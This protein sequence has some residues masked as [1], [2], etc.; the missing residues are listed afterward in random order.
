MRNL[1]NKIY[2]ISVL[3]TVSLFM[4]TCSDDEKTTTKLSEAEIE[5][6]VINYQ[7]ASHVIDSLVIWECD[8]S[9]DLM[10][11]YLDEIENLP[12][13]ENV[14][15]EN[16][17]FC[18]NLENVG[19][20][21][22]T[23]IPEE[24]ILPFSPLAGEETG[25]A[26]EAMTLSREASLLRAYDSQYL[27]TNKNVCLINQQSNDLSRQFVKQSLQKMKR[28]FEKKEF[29]VE[30]KDAEDFTRDFLKTSIHNY[31]IVFIKTH[32][33]YIG[34]RH[35]ML[36]GEEVS[37]KN[38]EEIRDYIEENSF[39]VEE[40]R[41]R[42][43]LRFLTAERNISYIAVNEVFINNQVHD[44][45]DN[46]IIFST[47]CQSLQDGNELGTAFINKNAGA[48][49]GYT[50]T[51]GIGLDAAYNLFSFM[52][53]G[54]TIEKAYDVLA[55]EYKKQ[56]GARNDVSYLAELK[57]VPSSGKNIY[58]I[59][60]DSV[61][62][63][64]TSPEDGKS[65]EQ[66]TILLS[67][68]TENGE[69]IR[70]GTVEINGRSYILDINPIDS[71]RFSQSIE[72]TKGKNTIKVSCTCTDEWNEQV[73]GVKEIELENT[74]ESLDLYT[75]LRWD[76]NYSDV[77]FHLLPPGSGMEALWTNID[78]F[79]ANKSTVWNAYL[80]IDDVD[81]KGPE[82]ITIPSVTAEGDY[83]L[84][85][86]YYAAHGAGTTKAWVDVQAL[87]GDLKSFGPYTL[88]NSGGNNGGDIWA[89]CKISYP[90]GKITPIEQKY[91][92]GSLRSGIILPPKKK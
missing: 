25:S 24:E 81:G 1:M 27:L 43:I 61:S 16:G 77:D 10:I 72:I 37:S 85:V 59:E 42:A 82:H 8:N 38:T 50:E 19:L 65:Y 15:L 91:T 28:D 45:S 40:E 57:Y 33:G 31:G 68:Y 54:A 21:A 47:A 6:T 30:I 32:G 3:L 26:F 71:T 88:T 56:T 49:L 66:R 89:V 12:G 84:Y 17:N 58:L 29:R 22:W 69:K 44:F 7:N 46:S 53:S 60:K 64:I 18:I 78:C 67:G 14:W 2:L 74:I 73:Y 80:D 39:N 20:I 63:I 5:Q 23:E 4:S 51:Q 9:I 83:T 48:Y 76:T 52:L 11:Q 87:D 55:E 41:Q 35:W 36:T 75:A 34:G 79:Y 92:L 62:I 86:H 70:H 13:V 90:E